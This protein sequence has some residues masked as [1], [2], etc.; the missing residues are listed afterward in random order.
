MFS[1]IGFRRNVFSHEG[2][3]DAFGSTLAKCCENENE[4]DF[5]TKPS[6]RQRISA[7]FKQMIASVKESFNF[8]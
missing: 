8:K 5:L 6:T 4:A 7:S 2:Q 1:L 3:E